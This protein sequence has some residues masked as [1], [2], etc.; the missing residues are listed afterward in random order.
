ME[1]ETELGM[2][3][4]HRQH[5]K[6]NIEKLIETTRYDQLISASVEQG[7]ITQTMRSIIEKRDSENHNMTEAEDLHNRHHKYFQKIT[8]RG[9]QAYNKLKEILRYLNNSSALAILESVDALSSNSGSDEFISL[10][11]QNRNRNSNSNAG[12]FNS[13][14][15][16]N[17]F[18]GACSF[19]GASSNNNSLKSPDSVD[20]PAL[21]NGVSTFYF[22]FLL[23]NKLI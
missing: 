9:P 7:L 20:M 4:C 21:P 2:A 16:V 5:I 18:N 15:N 12:S 13:N 19:R 23:T 11:S 3:Q 17:S 14:L 22:S 8:K 1:A 6:N 10:T